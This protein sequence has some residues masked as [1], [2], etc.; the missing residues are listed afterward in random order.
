MPE[1]ASPTTTVD[2]S[3][4]KAYLDRMGPKTREYVE[5]QI[6]KG[7]L[8]FGRGLFGL[9]S[10]LG[11]IGSISQCDDDLGVSYSEV[12]KNVP[13]S[14]YEIIKD[15][16]FL[17]KAIRNPAEFKAVLDSFNKDSKVQLLTDYAKSLE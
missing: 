14:V 5:N 7:D 10:I 11:D 8:E 15:T 6:T 2:I 1:T 12:I 4:W 3:E 17:R 16:N 13:L 9:P